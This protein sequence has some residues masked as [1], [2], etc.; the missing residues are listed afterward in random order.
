MSTIF[1]EIINRRDTNSYKWDTTPHD[2]TPMWVADMDFK[3]AP[4]IIEALR[5]RVDQGVF[6]YT[7][8]PEEYFNATVRWFE[9]QHDWKISPNNII[10]TSGVVPAIS[11]IIKALTHP[12]DSV[13]VQTPAYNCFFS[14]IRNNG[15]MLSSNRLIYDTDTGQYSIDYEDLKQKA[16]DPRT[17]LMILCNP[18]N[19]CGRVWTK[20][21]LTK[22]SK[23]CKQFDITILSDEIHCELTYPGHD[24]TPFAIVGN[25]TGC[26][27][28][29][30]I[31]PS[32]AFNIAGL[33]IANI[34]CPD[35]KMYA[36]IDRA[37]NDNEVCDV[38]PFGVIA[39][40]EAYNNG[41]AWLKSLR[42]YLYFNYL[43]LRDFFVENIPACKVTPLE[44]TYLAWINC[45]ATGLKASEI[46][47]KLVNEAKV[48]LNKGSMYG[49]GG[50]DFLR[51]NLACPRS[52]LQKVL[53]RIA[54]VLNNSLIKKM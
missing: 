33:Q 50:S 40:I 14:S 20:D 6:G 49:D 7:M 29:S 48:R 16:A 12:G 36:L 54:R 19:P 31:S 44:G 3:T 27:Y 23:I 11:A 52:V 35:H 45:S 15:C 41:L 28:V 51:I 37:I 21:E 38:N 8:V 42:D 5:R 53:P 46:E 2:V 43:Y 18:H 9:V 30:C 1:D 47:E 17:K 32:K 26:N 22:I 39:T 10:Y 24:Y 13:I 25:E 4:C 34:V